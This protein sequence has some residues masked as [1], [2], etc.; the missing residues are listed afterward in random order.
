M[1]KLLKGNPGRRPLNA[2]EPQIAP[3]RPPVP[4]SLEGDPTPLALVARAE[5]DRVV[6]QLVTAGIVG[7]IDMPILEA[8]ALTFAQWRLAMDEVSKHGSIVKIGKNDYPMQNPYIAV[9]NK[10]F[11]QWTA[12]AQ[13]L[14]IGA[15]SRSKISATPARESGLSKFLSKR[16]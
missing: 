1:L 15:A 3:G 12:M 10:A 9:A 11:K 7:E 8:Y 5:W 4:P 6:D 2:A 16:A 13:E 14:G